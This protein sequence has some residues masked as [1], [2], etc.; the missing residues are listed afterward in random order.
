MVHSITSSYKLIYVCCCSNSWKAS[1]LPR[2]E[3]ILICQCV[4]ELLLSWIKERKCDKK[5]TGQDMD[6]EISLTHYYHGIYYKHIFN[7]LSI[8]SAYNNEN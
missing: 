7:V 5:L 8:K 2:R 3:V 1:S 6:R 4:L